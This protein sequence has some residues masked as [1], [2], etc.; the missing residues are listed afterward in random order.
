MEF[1]PCICSFCLSLICDFHSLSLIF[2]KLL[3][4]HAQVVVCLIG[5]I[6]FWMLT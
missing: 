3:I 5:L 2:F 4:Q 6:I 1:L